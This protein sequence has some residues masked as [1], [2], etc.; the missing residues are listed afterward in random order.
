MVGSR[1]Y[2][3]INCFCRVSNY[4]SRPCTNFNDHI[5]LG[6]LTYTTGGRTYITGVVSWGA[7]CAR[8]NQPG[9]YARVTEVMDWING[10]LGQTC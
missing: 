2:T 9:V 3:K 5:I 10:Q 1:N 7:G 4:H 8:P 6:P